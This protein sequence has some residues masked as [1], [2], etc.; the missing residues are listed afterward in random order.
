MSILGPCEDQ[1]MELEVATW[2]LEFL[3]FYFVWLEIYG[4][5]G[6]VY[7]LRASQVKDCLDS[8]S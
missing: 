5:S 8:I 6:W 4:L 2:M 1:S 7:V 3:P